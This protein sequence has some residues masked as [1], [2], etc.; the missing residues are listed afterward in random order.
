[1]YYYSD[2]VAFKYRTRE[3][4]GGGN[5]GEFGEFVVICQIKCLQMSWFCHPNTACKS[6]FANILPSKS[7]IF[8]PLQIF[9]AYGTDALVCYQGATLK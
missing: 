1:M 6:K 3:I 7:S 2:F 8:L 9:P 4:F 5:I